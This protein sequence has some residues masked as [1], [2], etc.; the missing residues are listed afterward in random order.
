ME[1]GS[2]SG[3]AGVGE[4]GIETAS[5][6]APRVIGA[7]IRMWAQQQIQ[8]SS[9]AELGL[10]EGNPKL[11]QR[12]GAMISQANNSAPVNSSRSTAAKRNRNWSLEPIIV[13]YHAKRRERSM[14]ARALEDSSAKTRR[15]L[16]GACEIDRQ[17]Y[18]MRSLPQA[19][20][21]MREIK[22]DA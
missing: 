21:C 12:S 18:L 1:S 22:S 5:P 16:R 8:L 11:S 7:A 15:T 19:P 3:G 13:K 2:D 20:H 10:S 4:L 14:N 17:P 9:P 6:H